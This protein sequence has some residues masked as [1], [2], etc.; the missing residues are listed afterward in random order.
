MYNNPLRILFTT[1]VIGSFVF[2]LSCGNQPT[3]NT[4]NANQ[5]ANTAANSNAANAS[6]DMDAKNADF[7]KCELAWTDQERQGIENAILADIRDWGN[8]KLKKSLDGEGGNAPWMTVQVRRSQGVNDRFY[9]AVIIGG[10]GGNDQFK[11]LTDILNNYHD[12][13]KCV[14]RAFFLPAGSSITPSSNLRDV[15]FEWSACDFPMRP[16][17]DGACNCT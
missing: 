10:L 5:S 11:E 3:S 17:S 9:E 8:K 6:P 13:K 12:T 14:R 4:G 2:G 15:G 1:L 16:C 7:G